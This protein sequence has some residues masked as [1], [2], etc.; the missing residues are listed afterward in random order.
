MIARYLSWPAVSQIRALMILPSTYNII[1]S[2]QVRDWR[3]SVCSWTA[4]TLTEN[5]AIES[6]TGKIRYIQNFFLGTTGKQIRLVI[7]GPLTGN[8]LKNAECALNSKRVLIW[9][10]QLKAK[11]AVEQVW[12][13][14]N[15][16]VQEL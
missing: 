5:I 15:V 1:K 13:T 9:R 14:E 11:F 12:L 16:A 2:A 10:L 4:Y 6:K 3:I 7:S 8:C